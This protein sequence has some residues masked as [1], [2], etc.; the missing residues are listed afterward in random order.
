MRL[1]LMVLA[2]NHRKTEPLI[3]SQCLCRHFA[4]LERFPQGVK[5]GLVRIGN[6]G[7]LD[8]H[9]GR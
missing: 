4:P 6:G 9:G 7:G 2:L 1:D 5:N 3:I 8:H